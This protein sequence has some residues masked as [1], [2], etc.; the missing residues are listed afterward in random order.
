MKK[1]LGQFGYIT[2]ENIGDFCE[3]VKKMLEGKKFTFVSAGEI[4]NFR[5]D[6]KIHQEF[7]NISHWVEPFGA[8][9][10]V[11]DSYGVWS[12]STSMKDCN[13][14]KINQPVFYFGYIHGSD[15][16]LKISHWTIDGLLVHWVIVPE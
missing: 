1:R 9:F 11:N 16:H 10:R 2:A 6:V 7:K 13:S 8:G 4:Y 3:E 15:Q 5:P 14:P 12:C